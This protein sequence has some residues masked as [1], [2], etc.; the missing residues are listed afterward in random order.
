MADQS[1]QKQFE[2]EL[3]EVQGAVA[4]NWGWFLAL[5]ILLVVLGFAAI[6]FPFV[7]TI[8][9][10]VALGWVFLIGGISHFIHAFGAQGWRGVLLDMLVGALYVFAG[11]WLAFFPLT[12]ILPLTVM[13]AILFVVEG[14]FEVVLSFR[15]KPEAGWGYLLFSGIVAILAGV[16][17]TMG[18]PSS[19]TWAIGLLAGI[20]LLSSGWSFIFIALAGRDADST[21]STAAA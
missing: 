9:A 4:R 16:L 2:A 10:K 18:L 1:S 14:M 6:L 21:Q 20:N 19:A 3:A 7:S 12:G 15:M 13:L 17:I 8:A 11:A 5:G